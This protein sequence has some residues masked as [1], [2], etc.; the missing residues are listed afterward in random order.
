MPKNRGKY[1]EYIFLNNER[2]SGTTI[3]HITK[4]CDD[5]P[6]IIQ[7]SFNVELEDNVNSLKIKSRKLELD[8]I[9]EIFDNKLYK[10]SGTPQKEEDATCYINSRTPDDSE[11]PNSLSLSDAYLISRAFNEDLYPG[12]FVHE[13]RKIYF[14]MKVSDE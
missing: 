2:I 14:R 13:G 8:L 7:K 6:I 10:K 3:H 11:V 1:L 9:K 5:G 12:F 4:G